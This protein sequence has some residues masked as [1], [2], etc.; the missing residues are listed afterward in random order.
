M[1]KKIIISVFI[2]FGV[3][4]ITYP[5]LSNWLYQN[6]VQS[7]VE[8]LKDDEESLSEQELKEM[9]DLAEKYNSELKQSQ[10]QLTDPFVGTDDTIF[11]ALDYDSLLN[12][13]GNGL[14]GYVEIPVIAV[15]LPIFHGTDADV[16]EKGIGH[17]KGSSL[18]VGGINTHAVLTGHTGLNNLKLFSDLTELKKGDLFFLHVLGEDLAYEVCDIDVVKPEDTEKLLI[19]PDK[20]LVTLV[21]CTPYGINTHRLFVTGERTDYDTAKDL[22]SNQKKRTGDSQWMRSYRNAALIG[23]SVSILIIILNKFIFPK[24]HRT[25]KGL[26]G[27]EYYRF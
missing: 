13:Q 5:W 27:N 3:G 16:L 1:I 20:D 26:E 23:T 8:V 12:L 17:L 22:S 14:M 18:P 24:L 19:V 4:L 9:L 11:N 15:N 7:S 2:L 6:Q 25:N 10:V 21:T